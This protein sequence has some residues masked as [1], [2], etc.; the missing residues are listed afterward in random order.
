MVGVVTLPEQL[1]EKIKKNILPVWKVCFFSALLVGLIAHVYKITNWLPNW[2]GLVFRYDAQNMLRL[3]RWFLAVACAPSSFYDLPFINGLFAIIYHGL[4]AVCICKIF[5]VQKKVTAVLIGALVASFPAVTS[6]MMYNYVADGYALAFLLSCLAALFMTGE[7]PRFVLGAIFI[8][9]SAGIYQAYITVTIMLLILHLIIGLFN[10]DSIKT[11]LI[12]SLKFLL[13]GGC[14]MLVY[15]LV[16]NILL[17]VTHSALLDYQG[18]DNATSLESVDLFSSL[19][20]VKYSFLGYFFDFSKGLNVFNVTNVIVSVAA[21]ALYLADIIRKKLSVSKII[22]LCVYVAFLPIGA[23]VLAFINGSVDYHNLMKMGFLVFYLIFILQ[24][25]RTDFKCTK[26][27]SAKLWSILCISSVIIFNNIIIANVSYHKLNMAYEK[28]YGIL[29]RIADRIE[30]TEN[31]ENCDSILV[32]GSLNESKEYSAN[33]PP[34]MTGTT[35]GL[36]LRADDE[37]VGQSVLCSA[38]NDY[39]SKDYSFISGTKKKEL[40]TKIDVAAMENWPKKNSIMIVDN[41]IVI[42]LGDER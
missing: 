1:I 24:Y 37:V 7:K 18:F 39:C 8:T 34:D 23:S 21:V 2:D 4:G 10:D 3:G 40:F 35:D 17:G 19:Y 5:D 42:K 14:G 11:A 25:E 20:N 27:N 28:S 31:S 33:L 9:L 30:Q 38:I 36:I 41:T 12:K 13:T 16:L 22:L 26:L 29:V 15:Y 6:V 32:L